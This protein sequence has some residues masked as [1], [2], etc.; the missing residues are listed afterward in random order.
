ME[1]WGDDIS[2]DDI[3][4]ER[5]RA[6]EKAEKYGKKKEATMEELIKLLE[7]DD[8]ADDDS[9]DDSNDEIIL[10]RSE[11]TLKLMAK[12][13]NLIGPNAAGKDRR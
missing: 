7:G 8:E 11:R 5:R 12:K 1:T 3:A 4:Y 9:D 6:T 2:E 13:L 10:R